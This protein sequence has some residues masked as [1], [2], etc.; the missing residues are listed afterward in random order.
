MNL[1]D[2]LNLVNT[3]V[4]L[5]KNLSELKDHVHLDKLPEAPF[6]LAFNLNY[7]SQKKK[8]KEKELS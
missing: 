6:F 5:V 7:T 1:I 8:D 3:A 4:E 2:L